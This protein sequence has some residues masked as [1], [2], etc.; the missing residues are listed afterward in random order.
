MPRSLAFC[1]SHSVEFHRQMS[2][3]VEPMVTWN[4]G[5]E[6][7]VGEPWPPKLP[8]AHMHVAAAPSCGESAELLSLS[9]LG[10]TLSL[11]CHPLSQPAAPVPKPR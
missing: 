10:H 2:W 7:K 1:D 3:N 8:L 5:I 4:K 9:L 6:D 11:T